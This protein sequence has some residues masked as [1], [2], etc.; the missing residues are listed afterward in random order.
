MKATIKLI[1]CK[2]TKEGKDYYQNCVFI[3]GY[4]GNDLGIATSDK[5]Y[6]IGEE[7]DVFFF[8]GKYCI[9]DPDAVK[10]PINNENTLIE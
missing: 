2:K 3:N 4:Y 7:V 10:K 5:R 6:S 9:N 8:K 1:N